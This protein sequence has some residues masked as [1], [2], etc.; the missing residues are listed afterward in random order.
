MS[1]SDD[2][3]LV[4][5]PHST[6]HPALTPQPDGVRYGVSHI[7]RLPPY[8]ETAWPAVARALRSA[9]VIGARV[10]D[11]ARALWAAE[12]VS[13]P[14]SHPAN[15]L[16]G[17][18]AI[19]E[20]QLAPLLRDRGLTLKLACARAGY[21]LERVQAWMRGDAKFKARIEGYRRE[22]LA[23]LHGKM[24]ELGEKGSEPAIK[25]LLETSGEEEYTPKI[26][27]GRITDDDVQ[28]SEPYQRFVRMVGAV[29]CD[30]CRERLKEASG[31]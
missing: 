18:R 25:F 3:A 27:V 5:D 16:A 8:L 4:V 28:N 20:E 10:D 12:S 13:R 7:R 26:R 19:A 22:G 9:G 6:L 17:R 14:A 21:P 1:D 24:H 15:T 2:L 30:G 29:V 23:K 31:E 11:V